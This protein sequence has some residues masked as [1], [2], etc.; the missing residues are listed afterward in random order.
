MGSASGESR[1]PAPLLLLPWRA[2]CRTLPFSGIR[3]A[4]NQPHSCHTRRARPVRL[5]P[6][7]PMSPCFIRSNERYAWHGQSLLITNE[8]GDC[9]SDNAMSGY[10]FREARHL[11]TMRMEVNG[12]SPWLSESSANEPESLHFS[13]VYPELTSFGGGGSGQSQ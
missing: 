4:C 6:T 3:N 12:V 13:Y 10:Y 8:R 5:R 11:R 7:L 2:P 9:G 1:G